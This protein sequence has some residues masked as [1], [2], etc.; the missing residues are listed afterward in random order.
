MLAFQTVLPEQIL[1]LPGGPTMGSVSR[2]L[3]ATETPYMQENGV[4][5]SWR[6]QICLCHI[7]IYGA[8]MQAIFTLPMAQLKIIKNAQHFKKRS[9]FFKN[10]RLC[11][12]QDQYSCSFQDDIGFPSVSC[13]YALFPLVNTKKS[14]LGL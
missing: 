12:F 8:R 4:H 2:L 9:L 5:F 11:N 13:K 1:T 14:A 6:Q 10:R 3:M 7:V